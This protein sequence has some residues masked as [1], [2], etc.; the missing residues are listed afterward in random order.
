MNYQK[1]KTKAYVHYIIHDNQDR[2]TT[3]QL[4]DE[5]IK[6]G[7]YIYTHIHKRDTYMIY[8]YDINTWNGIFFSPEKKGN[9]AICNNMN[10]LED[11]MLSEMS[12]TEKTQIL[13][14]GILKKK[15]NS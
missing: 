1:T 5:T 14:C 7:E 9:A 8:S 15:L 12:H 2:E 3:C 4:T 10:D 11:I 6:M 13:I